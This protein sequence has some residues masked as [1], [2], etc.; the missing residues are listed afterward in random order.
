MMDRRSVLTMGGAF[1]AIAMGTP[2][3][4]QYPQRPIKIV[5]GFPAGGTPDIFLRHYAQRLGSLAGQPIIVENRPGA[6]AIIAA[7]TVI[8]AP[9]DGYTL[10]FAPDS[11]PIGNRFL[12]KDLAYDPEHDIV[13]LAPMIWNSFVLLVNSETPAKT[14][15]ELTKH[16]RQKSGK[17]LYGQPN[18]VSQLLAEAYGKV[19]GFH[20]EAVSFKG[21]YQGVLAVQAGEID[22]MFADVGSAL[23]GMKSGKL[24]PLA[25]TSKRRSEAMPDVPSMAN[26]G[27]P[28]FDIDGFFGLY[29]TP[30]LAGELKQDIFGWIRNLNANS[31]IKAALAAVG[32]ETFPD[33]MM[34]RS[35]RLLQEKRAVWRK[36]VAIAQLQPT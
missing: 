13:L 7:T 36:L 17:A 30:K 24:R 18:S 6:G 14:V 10:L 19:D 5:I 25:I 35:D 2:A 4:A 27:Y 26:I 31:E 16:L 22:F 3:F 20:A 33:D 23:A 32:A 1:A 21:A 28:D 8:A 12:F 34:Q 29:G 9:P 11:T 15:D